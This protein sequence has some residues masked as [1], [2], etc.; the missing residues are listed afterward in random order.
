MTVTLLQGDC[1][2][3]LPT[4]AGI[5]AMITDPPYPNNGGHFVD[6]VET[7]KEILLAV[8]VQSLVFW[9][10]IE[11]PIM[12]LPLVAVH[13]CTYNNVNGRPYEAIY[14]FH[15][16]GKKRRSDV[17]NYWMIKQGIGPADKEYAGHPTQKAIVVM[18]WLIEKTTKEGDTILDPFMGSGTTGVAA[19]QLGRNF[20]GCEINP[21]YFAIAQRRIEAAQVQMVMPL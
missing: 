15:P 18:K 5:D 20:I 7:A 9:S 14:H 1:L 6:A 4:L 13:I 17:I 3:I 8:D 11:K 2:E 19:V 12:R 16:D 10:E 21:D